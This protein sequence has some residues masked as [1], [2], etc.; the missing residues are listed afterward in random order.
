MYDYRATQHIRVMFTEDDEAN[1]QQWV[2]E[3]NTAMNKIF[4]NK[5]FAEYWNESEVSVHIYGKVEY[6]PSNSYYDPDEYEY[7][8]VFIPD[9]DKDIVKDW[10]TGSPL[11]ITDIKFGEIEEF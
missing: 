7:D 11:V 1:I 2:D 6:Y 3:F 5:F 4:P 9:E 10:F 8:E